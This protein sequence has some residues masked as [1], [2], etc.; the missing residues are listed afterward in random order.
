MRR[1]TC[2][3]DQRATLGAII[4]MEDEVKDVGKFAIAGVDIAIMTLICV[5]LLSGPPAFETSKA[6]V[7]C[8][9]SASTTSAR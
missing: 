7:A 9:A 8:P 6:T 3:L 5:S 2:N 1:L 4:R